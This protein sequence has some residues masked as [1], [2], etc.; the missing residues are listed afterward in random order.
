MSAPG[1]ITGEIKT[2]QR[3]AAVMGNLIAVLGLLVI[4]YPLTPATI[5]VL[6]LGW[7]LIVVA[8]AQFILK[9]HF[10]TTGSAVT[11]RKSAPT[12]DGLRT[13]RQQ[14]TDRI[15]LPR[16]TEKEPWLKYKPIRRLL[17]TAFCSLAVTFAAARVGAAGETFKQSAE[18]GKRT[19]K[20]SE[21]VSK[22]VTQLDKTEQALSSVSQAQSKD[23]KKRYESFSKEAN[24]LEKAQK[25]ATSDIDEMKS[26]GRKYFSSWDTSIAQMSSP[27][28]RQTSTERRSKV[29]KDHDELAATL[30]DIGRQLQPFMSNLHDLKAFLETDLSPANVGK[31][32]EMIQKSQAD[33]QA[34][35]DKIAGAQTTLKEFLSEAP[36]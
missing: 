13:Y 18:L 20:T 32:S 23:L 4:G 5:R 8:I 21:D 16:R 9:H 35:K 2:R 28:L 36:K 29:M 30:S 7:V 6:L 11:I 14:L 31:A 17:M 22:Y 24:K 15:M 27:E 1:N 25:Q 19:A 12:L 34:L 3:A 26:T 10:Q 33:A